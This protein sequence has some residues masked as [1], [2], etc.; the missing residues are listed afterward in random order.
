M[1]RYSPRKLKQFEQGKENLIS[2]Q[3]EGIGEKH[4]IIHEHF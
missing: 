4:T 1:S 3:T 2:N